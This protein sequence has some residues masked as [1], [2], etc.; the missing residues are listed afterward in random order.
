MCCLLCT[1]FSNP[2]LTSLI[3]LSAKNRR[4]SST[5]KAAMSMSIRL[6]NEY[7]QAFN[8]MSKILF[9]LLESVEIC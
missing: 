4:L 6:T 7:H 5:K 1:F 8:K 9:S 2:L 3:R